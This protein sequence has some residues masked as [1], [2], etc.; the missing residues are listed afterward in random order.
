MKVLVNFTECIS[1][2]YQGG[3]GK[4]FDRRALMEVDNSLP[5]ASVFGI[6]ELKLRDHSPVFYDVTDKRKIKVNS[7]EVFE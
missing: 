5:V 6:I 7:I 1:D 2:N 4:I 3:S